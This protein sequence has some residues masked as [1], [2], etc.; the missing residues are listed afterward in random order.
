MTAH[1]MRGLHSTLAVEHGAP[2][3][4][5]PPLSGTSRATT[6]QS[7]VKPEAVAGAKQRRV[8]TM[9]GGERVAS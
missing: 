8:I 5:S 3:T 9:F 7:Y 6:L 2:L 4:S 1:G